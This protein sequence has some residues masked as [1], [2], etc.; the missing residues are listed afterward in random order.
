MIST[1]LACA[2]SLQT[3]SPGASPASAPPADWRAAEAGTLHGHV[4]LTFADRFAKAGEAYFSPDDQRIVFQA[5]EKLADGS[6][7]PPHYAMYVADVVRNAAGAIGSIAN[8]RRVSPPGSANTCGWFDPRDPMT[9]LFAST[10]G[11]PTEGQA[12]GY[13]RGTGRYRWMFPPEMRI[14]M[15]DLKK[16]DGSS[17]WQD[18]LTPLVGDGKAYVAEGSTSPDGKWLLYCDL[19]HGDGDIWVL[20]RENGVKT[21]LVSAPGYD[22]G[23]FFA[24]DGRRICYRSDRSANNILQLYVAD[25]AFDATGHIVGIAQEHQVT[26][27]SNVNWCPFFHPSGAFLVFASSAMGHRN[28]EVFAVDAGVADRDGVPQPRY[29]TNLRRVTHADG[30]DVLPVFSHDGRWMLWTGQRDEGATSQL[31]VAEWKMPPDPVIAPPT[32]RPTAGGSA[33]RRPD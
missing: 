6:E 29:G 33:S 4:Q 18:S 5:V 30:A 11:P 15:C 23:P 13:Q 9:L 17:Q 28:Y 12:P 19:A 21:A 27:D 3:T 7:P 20:N 31:Y 14:L 16:A 32:S 10:I 25:L 24:P 1:L 22:G 2:L 26:R 8:I